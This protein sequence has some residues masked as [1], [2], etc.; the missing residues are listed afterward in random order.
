MVLVSA[1]GFAWLRVLSWLWS[2]TCLFSLLLKLTLRVHVPKW[3]ILW[4]QC[5]YIGSTLRP[6]YILF[7]YMDP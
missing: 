1:L 6:K 4:A 2:P 7:G 5:A 3:Y